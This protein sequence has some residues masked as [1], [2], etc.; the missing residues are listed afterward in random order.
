VHSAHSNKSIKS[1]AGA[2]GGELF[3]VATP[4]GNL[5]DITLRALETLKSADLIACEDTRTSGVLMQHYGIPTKLIAY[6]QHNEAQATARLVG[7]LKEGKKIALISDA[8]TPLLSDPGARLVAAAIEAGIRVTP[9]PG[10]SAL[11]AAISI[12]GLPAERFFYAG[13]LPGKAGERRQLLETAGTLPVTLVFY[14]APHRL[15]ATLR[16]LEQALGD[17]PAAIARELTKL[18]EECRRGTLSELAAH[19]EATPPRGECVILVGGAEE[20]AMGDAEIDAALR[21]QL[22]GQTLRE[23]VDEVTRL[24]RRP[25]REIYALAL[26]LKKEGA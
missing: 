1:Q 15:A 16:L 7:Q 21:Q 11:L 13:F 6:H 26:A 2:P 3:V 8:G 24:A 20:T 19:Y 25:R 17:R 23:A 18:H 9:L 4:I 12:A 10:A 5:G 22:A 14:E